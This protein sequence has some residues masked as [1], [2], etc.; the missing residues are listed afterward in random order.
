MLS[1]QNL[2]HEEQFTLSENFRQATNVIVGSKMVQC[3]TLACLDCT[4]PT[5]SFAGAILADTT[6]QTCPLLGQPLSFA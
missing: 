4:A 5:A 6:G 3:L 2:W 1:L